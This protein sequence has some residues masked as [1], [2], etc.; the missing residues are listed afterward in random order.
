MATRKL[1]LLVVAAT[2]A[3][4]PAFNFQ[5]PTMEGQGQCG[6]AGPCDPSDFGAAPNDPNGFA[7]S[8]AS[9]MEGDEQRPMEGTAADGGIAPPPGEG[10]CCR[11]R[12]SRW[13]VPRARF[14]S[15]RRPHAYALLVHARPLV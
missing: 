10:T 9:N 2:L 1:S 3:G 6:D 4:C 7:G 13:M 11:P 15:D 8:G 5:D 12:A 14:R